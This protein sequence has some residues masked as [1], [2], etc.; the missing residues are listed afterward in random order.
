MVW[1][2]KVRGTRFRMIIGTMN[3]VRRESSE[4][5]NCTLK[6]RVVGIKLATL[7]GNL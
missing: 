7:T 3:S 6:M 2:L 5:M 1:L 4:W